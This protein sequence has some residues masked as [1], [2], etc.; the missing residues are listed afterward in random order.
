MVIFHTFSDIL[1]KFI[2]SYGSFEDVSSSILIY[3]VIRHNVNAKIITYT[4]KLS[5]I[6]L[7]DQYVCK[8]LNIEFNSIFRPQWGRDDPLYGPILFNIFNLI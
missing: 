4:L 1:S 8:N 5:I 7:K 2:E 6:T 3:F